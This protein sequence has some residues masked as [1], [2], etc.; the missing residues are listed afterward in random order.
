MELGRLEE[1]LIFDEKAMAEVQRCADSGDALSQNEVWIYRV[2]RGRLYLR[3]GKLDEAEQLLLEAK[4][5][6][7]E[8]RSVYRLFAERALIEI[9]QLRRESTAMGENA[10]LNRYS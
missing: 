10:R 6:I 3:L 9:E 7:H 2:N 4:P 1:A 8:R 5:R